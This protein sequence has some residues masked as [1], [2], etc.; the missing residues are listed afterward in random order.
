MWI[1]LSNNRNNIRIGVVYAPQ[2]K[3]TNVNKLKLMY[4]SIKEQIKEAKAKRQEVLIVGDFN[5]KVGTIVAGNT[6][7]ISK[8]GK[9][10]KE[11]IKNQN[12]RLLNTS[13]KCNGLWT[14][15]EGEKKSVLDYMIVEAENEELVKG[16][17]IDNER[18]YTPKHLVE[19][20]NVYTDHN[21]MI[22]EMNWNM[23]YKE[24]E[25]TRTCLN[26]KTKVE[27][28]KKTSKGELLA[29]WKTE[30][31][32]LVKFR[33]WNEKVVGIAEDIFKKKIKKKTERKEI[34]I[35]KRKKKELKKRMS[36][37]EEKEKEL[38]EKRRKLIERHIEEYRRQVQAYKTQ[39]VAKKIKSE[40]GFDGSVFWEYLK[41]AEG[42]KSETATA[43]RNEEG[44]L[45]EDPEAILAIYQKFYKKLLTG[46]P[47][48]TKE[49]LEVEQ[50][51]NKYVEVLERKAL[52]EGI[53]PFSKEE[54]DEVKREIKN[55]KAPD[56][57]GWRYELIKNAGQD[58]EE[59]I[60]HMINK[61]V[62][63]FT[64]PING[65]R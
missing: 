4:K 8:G 37:A 65:W 44:V 42:R 38:L 26:N 50:L 35:L 25:N 46:K 34:R 30:K 57:Q 39:C 11:L 62:S 45:E 5:C 59:S 40:K 23:R 61:L 2:E 22:L 28:S 49:G 47:M 15:V 10:L 6:E 24:K 33:Q 54:Y 60:L 9:L 14:R 13:K 41:K 56:L 36:K 63:T 53:E 1:T 48:E 58:L 31:E 3:E 32:T 29:M 55:G 52:R 18:E 21:T 12:L 27:F 19:G 7:E 20:R 17:W 64:V 43:L 16:M 51:V